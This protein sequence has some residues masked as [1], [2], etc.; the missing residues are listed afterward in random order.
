MRFKIFLVAVVAI[1]KPS[2]AEELEIVG[3]TFSPVIE[4]FNKSIHWKL[5]ASNELNKTLPFRSIL[6]T[7]DLN[8]CLEFTIKPYDE[9]RELGLTSS[10]EQCLHYEQLY[11]ALQGNKFKHFRYAYK[12]DGCPSLIKMWMAYTDYRH[13]TI[14]TGYHRFSEAPFKDFKVSVVLVNLDA[15]KSTSFDQLKEQLK[16]IWSSINPKGIVSLENLTFQNQLSDF[17]CQKCD[18]VRAEQ[19]QENFSQK[20]RDALAEI[21][22]N[23]KLIQINSISELLLFAAISFTVIML[24]FNYSSIKK[25]LRPNRVIPLTNQSSTIIVHH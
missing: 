1:I 13:F 10:N 6:N 23:I 18:F 12:Y 9:N 25:K 22:Q 21:Q 19:W 15:L 17:I 24:G 11:V 7:F 8:S 2:N 5:F 4:N 3:N 20:C 14:L 16:Q